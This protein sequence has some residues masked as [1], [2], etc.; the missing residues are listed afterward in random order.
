MDIQKM[1]YFICVA[2]HLNFTKAANDCF[3]AQTAMSRHI[4]SME[5]ELGVQLFNRNS[6]VV[7]LTPAGESLYRDISMQ[8]LKYDEAISRAKS[9]DKGYVDILRIGFGFLK[10]P[11][12]LEAMRP[13]RTA[14]PRVEVSI[15]QY[16]A[17]EM[18]DMLLDNR[19]DIIYLLRFQI[20]GYPQI[21]Y[22]TLDNTP[23]CIAVSCTH[24]LAG[25]KDIKP[26]MLNGA[27]VISASDSQSQ[28]SKKNL[29]EKCRVLGFEPKEII[30]TNSNE[31]KLLHLQTS[32]TIAFFHYYMKNMIAP[33]LV[34]LDIDT[35]A[36]DPNHLQ[37]NVACR[38]FSNTKWVVKD[39]FDMIVTLDYSPSSLMEASGLR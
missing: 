28:I 3:I 39:F 31:A 33:N 30:Q 11:L 37:D 5:K 29:F 12:V 26:E 15:G 8:L 20:M 6:R 10:R 24:P 38:L 35:T 27:T 4:A 9:I 13:F 21:E 18:I 17:G 34:F 25:V 1:R 22:R 14:Y 19:L 2:K 32:N 7:Q 16:R 36:S 23:P